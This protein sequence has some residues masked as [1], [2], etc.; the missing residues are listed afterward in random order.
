MRSINQAPQR[1]RALTR[2]HIRTHQWYRL[3]NIGT[4][5]LLTGAR[6]YVTLDVHHSS[7]RTLVKGEYNGFYSNNDNGDNGNN[8]CARR[9]PWDAGNLYPAAYPDAEGSYKLAFRSPSKIIRQSPQC[10]HRAA[11]DRG[12][13][14]NSDE[15]SR[16]L[17]V[18]QTQHKLRFE[19]PHFKRSA[20]VYICAWSECRRAA[21]LSG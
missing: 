11:S 16:G 5:E 12:S 17:A 14:D 7:R 9:I 8:N 4:N 15:G 6:F 18:T 21:A 1:Q 3:A 20:A 13:Y 10:W 19:Q 2:A